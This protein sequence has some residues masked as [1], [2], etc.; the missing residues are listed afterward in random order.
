MRNK[1][2]GCKHW[3]Q[4]RQWFHFLSYRGHFLHQR[5]MTTLLIYS[6]VGL[7]TACVD[8]LLIIS[9]HR[10]AL[11]FSS[12]LLV[13]FCPALLPFSS[14]AFFLRPHPSR[15][16]APAALFRRVGCAMLVRSNRTAQRHLYEAPEIT[17][18]HMTEQSSAINFA[19]NMASGGRGRPRTRAGVVSLRA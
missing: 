11:A 12:P 17:T 16:G 3:R 4:R 19:Y 14:L 9:S 1:K 13:S 7:I 15:S 10:V 18:H 2:L 5:H 6:R 8:S